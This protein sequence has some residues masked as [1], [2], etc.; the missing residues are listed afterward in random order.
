MIS[1]VT[2]NDDKNGNHKHVFDENSVSV[3]CDIVAYTI[4]GFDHDNVK[5]MKKRICNNYYIFKYCSHFMHLDFNTQ[6]NK[7]SLT[8]ML[9]SI[10]NQ[11]VSLSC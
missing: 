7:Q 5:L 2:Y 3:D 6:I 8:S 4:L 1:L 9:Y 10:L 11:F